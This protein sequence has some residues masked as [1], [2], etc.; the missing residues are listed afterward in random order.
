SVDGNPPLA[1]AALDEAETCLESARDIT[2]RPAG[3]QAPVVG[4]IRDTQHAIE[5]CDCNLPGI[6]HTRCNI[7][8]AQATSPALSDEVE[9][10]IGE[11]EQ[12]K[13]QGRAQGTDA[14]WEALDE[15]VTRAQSAVDTAQ[16]EGA[17]DPL[18]QHTALITIDTELDEQ[19]DTV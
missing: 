15:V 13:A 11:A 3:E 7:S 1:A 19:L 4:F 2:T 17:Q 12:L 14:N 8:Q 16:Q 6:E 18:G 9:G 10:E 5:I